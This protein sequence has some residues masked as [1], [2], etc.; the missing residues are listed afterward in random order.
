MK[1]NLVWFRNDL[2]LSDNL[3]LFKATQN[4]KKCIGV[5]CF[6]P[7]QFATTTY[8]FKKTE[9][10]RTQFLIETVSE[11]KENLKS[12]NISLFVYHEKP[13][14]IVPKLVEEH[15]IDCI[16]TQKEWT[17][18]EVCVNQNI[19]KQLQSQEKFKNVPFIESYDQF[20]FSPDNI[21]FE[22]KTIPKIF[23]DFRKKCEKEGSILPTISVEKQPHENLVPNNTLLP[24]LE[25]LRF[26][27]FERHPNTAFPFKGG[28]NQALLRLEN[29]FWETQ[30]LSHY[31]QTRN[32]LIGTNYS[33]KFSPWLANGSLS[34][35]TIYWKIKEYENTIGANEDTYWLFFELLW[36]DYFKYISLQQG[37]KIF[38]LQGILDKKYHWNTNL[39]A[40]NQWISGQTNEPFVNANMIELAKT[41]FMSNRGRQNVASFW[42][43][44]W[45]QDWRIGAAYFESMLIDY[46]VHSNYVNWMY[47][48]GV[49]NDPRDRKFNIQR[50][51]ELYDANGEYRQLWLNQ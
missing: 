16:Y 10:F 32:G 19:K 14:V 44:E 1:N 50:Q 15:Q 45:Q 26:Q 29:Y 6:D 8:G 25:D 48:A 20:L 4:S 2:R 38:Q 9:K 43:K 5:Y 34:A 39:K 13:E 41:G 36:R 28:E 17:S 51:A 24:T 37:S 23:T 21:P 12:K 30:N 22:I 11:L 42:A 31:K 35:K 7:R 27:T 46:D 18:E 47:T 33:S 3:S 49:G 40:F